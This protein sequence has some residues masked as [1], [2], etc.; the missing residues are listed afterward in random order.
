MK[1]YI[2]QGNSLFV[3][4]TAILVVALL[5]VI[6]IT[7]VFRNNINLILNNLRNDIYM[8]G[9]NALF[10]IERDL[11]GQDINKLYEDDIKKL[12]EKEI[13][14]IWGLDDKLKNGDG[15]VE[16]AE[17]LEICLLEKGTIDNVT[18]K[19][20]SDLTV[21]NVIKV[22][23]KAIALKDIFKDNLC[24]NIHED[25]RIRKLKIND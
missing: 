25:I 15:I 24:F 9:R 8:I 23:L 13:S 17:I 18:K 6:F 3:V 10:S 1:T 2:K 22:K 14:Y 7:I 20:I 5:T 16:S 12:I 11:M 19:E 4:L 21:H